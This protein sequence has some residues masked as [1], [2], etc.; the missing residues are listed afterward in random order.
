MRTFL[1]HT[2]VNPRRTDPANTDRLLEKAGQLI[3]GQDQLNLDAVPGIVV[4][5]FPLS[6]GIETY[7]TTGLKRSGIGPTTQQYW[8]RIAWDDDELLCICQY[9]IH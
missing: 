2:H 1:P 6:T 8:E 3:L 4:R 5:E 9:I 7:F